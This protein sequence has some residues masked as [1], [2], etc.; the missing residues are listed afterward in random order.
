MD[1]LDSCGGARNLPPFWLAILE[2]ARALGDWQTCVEADRE[3][4]RLG[5]RVEFDPPSRFER[6]AIEGSRPIHPPEEE[7]D[8][9]S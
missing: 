9:T 1:T 3:L 4:K 8:A 2:R 7:G 5:V 6:A